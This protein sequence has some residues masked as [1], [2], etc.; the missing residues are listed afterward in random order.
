MEKKPHYWGHRERLRERLIKTGAE[1]LHD[2]EVLE[3][4]LTYAFPRRDVKPLAK[5]LI[6]HF[7]S[8]SNALDASVEELQNVP[9]LTP[10]AALL[11]PL[12]KEASGVYLAEKMKPRDLL[13]SPQ[14]AVNFARAKLA[15]KANEVFM[16]LYLN[17]RNEAIDY[18]ILH[19]G[20]LDSSVVY[21]RRIIE[22]AINHRASELLLIHNHPSGHTDPS[23]EDKRITQT[24]LKAT[25]TMDI[26]VL[27]HI[28]VGKGGYFS[29]AENHLLEETT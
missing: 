13:T 29:F 15:G 10:R 8:F 7:G 1:G 17:T 22:G 21:P 9:G 26:R 20:T 6:E 14:A 25:Q 12:V 28:I 18:E 27:D 16:V 3:L 4:L 2:Y 19:E 11:L 5:K 23:P 24:I